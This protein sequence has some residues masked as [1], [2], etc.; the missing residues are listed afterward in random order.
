MTDLADL[1]TRATRE[2]A[3]AFANLA[4]ARSDADTLRADLRAALLELNLAREL[5]AYHGLTVTR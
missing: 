2:R 5:L 4:D 3:Q 1:L